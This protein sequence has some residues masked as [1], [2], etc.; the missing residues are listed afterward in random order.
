MCGFV[1]VIYN[2]KHSKEHLRDVTNRMLTPIE[3]RGPDSSGIWLNEKM[4][5]TLGHRRLSIIDLSEN[6]NQPM[7][8]RSTRFVISYNGEV[9]NFK[10]LKKELDEANYGPWR[11]ES[12][13]EVILAAIEHWGIE[14]AISKFIG[15]FCFAI[16]DNKEELLHIVR[17]RIG[18][19]PVYWAI[20]D[21][22]FI[23]ASELKSLMAFE[24]WNAEIDRNSL[25]LFMK[26][27]YVP[28]PATIFKNV[29]QLEAAT[30]LTFDK[31]KNIRKNKYWLLGEI[32]KNGI[33]QNNTNTKYSEGEVLDLIDNSV[34]YR[35]MSDVPIGAFLSGGIDSS[36][37]VALMQKNSIS[38]VNTFSIGFSIDSYDEAIYSKK[39]AKHLNTNHTE[40]I[41]EPEDAIDIIPKLPQV[42]DEPFSDSSQ[43]PTF[44]LSRLTSKNVKVALSGDGGDEV[45]GG[46]N[47]YIYAD[48]YFDKLN[49]M[50]IW[51]QNASK[52]FIH[53]IQEKSWDSLVKYFPEKYALNHVGD[54]FYKLASVIGKDHVGTYKTLISDWKFEDDLIIGDEIYRDI[55]FNKPSYFDTTNSVEYMQLMDQ[56]NYLPNDILTKVDRASM[57]NSL[58][59]RVPYLDHRI[60]E[61]M[62]K[63]PRQYK[64]N[65]GISKVLLR[66]IL[67]KYAEPINFNRA[68]SGFS[69][70][71]S[72][73]LRGPL[74]DWAESLLSSH[75][76]K[77]CGL[78][79]HKTINKKWNEHQLGKNN[80]GSHIWSILMFNAWYEHWVEKK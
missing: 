34:K 39:L 76:I 6:G 14:R 51:L 23:F 36:A 30:I 9:Y 37:I 22:N 78:L 52:N 21:G 15:M 67:G 69:L 75:T 18:I 79:N 25:A 64:I 65:N 24:T 33:G 73:W 46:Y 70:P 3:H 10:E 71:I 4:G 41:L 7:V 31:N 74:K 38:P 66:K 59:V 54:K 56:M 47:R 32:A 40:Y 5:I 44:L 2:K 58:E 45:F 28:S 62:W 12:D 35:L 80:W 11:G 55:D 42:Y 77:N 57:A 53:S 13:T 48:K 43:I 61:A 50:P 72:E 1:G 17:D 49:S 19:K 63:L 27:K 29:Y 68:K 20:Q 8:S 26:Y 60:I 16:W